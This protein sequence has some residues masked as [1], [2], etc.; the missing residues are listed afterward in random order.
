MI[1]DRLDRIGDYPFD[2]LRALLD[3]HKPQTEEAPLSL[4]L[5]EPQ[6]PAPDIVHQTLAESGD[7]WGKYPPIWGTPEFRSAVHQWLAQRYGL[8]NNMFDPDR[9]IIPVSGT[10]EA[11]FM[12]AFTVIPE[13]VSGKTPA[14]LMPNPFYQVYLGA[15]ALAGAES[16]FVPATP[17]TNFLPDFHSLDTETLD[18][19][20]L[21]YY[22]TPANPQGTSASVE[23]LA[24]IVE[25]ARKHDFVIVF[26][27]CY[28]EIY[29]ETPPAGGI[30]ACAK[31]GG[32][33]KNVLIMNSLSKRSSVPGLR[34]GFVAGDPEIMAR[35]KQV[36][37]YGGAP[38]PMP[39]LAVATALWQDEKHVAENRAFYSRKFDL[40]D[41][42]LSGKHGYYRPDGGFYLWLDVGDSE[43]AALKLWQNAALRVIPGAY[44]A[45][46]GRDGKNPGAAY[47]RCALVHD[48]ETTGQALDRLVATL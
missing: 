22:C 27:E 32:S 34:S 48:L 47:I 11:L 45:K 42:K 29:N 44:F 20:A 23:K 19:T 18:R 39:L 15:A 41:Q 13:S 26:D 28:S 33:L 3:S 4:A 1:N 8:S 35:F 9:T 31:L 7:L 12:M 24:S 40:A 43:A 10:R 6:H 38:P 5:G 14:V 46:T 30:E 16:V 37:D 25:L 36:R 17:E 21:A 2:R